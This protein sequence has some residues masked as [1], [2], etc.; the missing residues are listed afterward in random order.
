MGTNVTI[1]FK[2]DA[3]YTEQEAVMLGGQF[4]EFINEIDDDANP[5]TI[6]VKALDPSAEEEKTFTREEVIEILKGG[7]ITALITLTNVEGLALTV[8]LD[9]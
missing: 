8:R 5:N 3:V 4:A 7:D 6:E 1:K 2:S 9:N